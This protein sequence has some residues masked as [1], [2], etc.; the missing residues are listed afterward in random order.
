MTATLTPWTSRLMKKFLPCNVCYPFLNK[1][2]ENN[3]FNMVISK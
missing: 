1:V 3:P 2:C